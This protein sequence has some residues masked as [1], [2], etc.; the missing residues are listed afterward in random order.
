MPVYSLGFVAQAQDLDNTQLLKLF[1]LMET[2]LNHPRKEL[3]DRTLTSINQFLSTIDRNWYPMT[4]QNRIINDE[5]MFFTCDYYTNKTV[6]GFISPIYKVAGRDLQ[7]RF[8][9]YSAYPSSYNANLAEISQMGRLVSKTRNSYKGT[10]ITYEFKGIL[11]QYSTF[12]PHK[13]GFTLY[14]KPVTLYKIIISHI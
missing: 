6:T 5:E 12:P 13:D 3:S 8:E 7:P 2:A 4:D 1:G 11:F 14:G 9:Y 10:D